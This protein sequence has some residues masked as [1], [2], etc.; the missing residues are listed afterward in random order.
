[1]LVVVPE[2]IVGA[3]SREQGIRSRAGRR[4]SR[5]VGLVIG[6]GR[7]LHKWLGPGPGG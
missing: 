7:G 5:I 1:M 3:G 4:K 6:A 2:L